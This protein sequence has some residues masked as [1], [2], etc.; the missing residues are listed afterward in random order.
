MCGCVDC[1]RRLHQQEDV[2]VWSLEGLWNEEKNSG[3]G[4]QNG[5]QGGLVA[6]PWI[7]GICKKRNSNGEKRPCGTSD[8]E[9]P[10]RALTKI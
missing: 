8:G 1:K 6:I 2:A 3:H 7:Q 10:N 9:A 4:E 5:Q